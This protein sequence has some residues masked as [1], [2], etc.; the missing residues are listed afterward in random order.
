L[1][2]IAR[3]M[4]GFALADLRQPEAAVEKLL[5]RSNADVRL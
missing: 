5:E 2:V 4:L 1:R 3:T